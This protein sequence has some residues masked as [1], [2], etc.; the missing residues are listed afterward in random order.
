LICK[1]IVTLGATYIERVKIYGRQT[2]EEFPAWS[3]EFELAGQQLPSSDLDAANLVISHSSQ[4]PIPKAKLDT[5]KNSLPAQNANLV[6]QSRTKSKE[7][8]SEKHLKIWA[9]LTLLLSIV[10]LFINGGLALIS[11]SIFG[12]FCSKISELQEAP[13]KKI[14]QEQEILRQKQERLKQEEKQK[15]YLILLDPMNS[16]VKNLQTTLAQAALEEFRKVEARV[17]VGVSSNDLP[18]VLASAKYQQFSL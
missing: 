2:G 5:N 4:T 6:A 9:W 10:L 3:Q 17:N 18:A 8:A 12:Y 1:L 7:V 14:K 15:S 13:A 16:P 11:F